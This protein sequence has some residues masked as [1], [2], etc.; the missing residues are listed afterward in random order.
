MGGMVVIA[1]A[2]D[3]IIQSQRRRPTCFARLAE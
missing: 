2:T 3:G 1:V